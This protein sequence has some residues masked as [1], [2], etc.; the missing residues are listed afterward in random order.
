MADQNHSLFV[1]VYQGQD[2][3]ERVYMTLR[4]LEKDKLKKIDIKTAAVATRKP[5]GKIKIVHKRRVTV[6]KG[7]V[8]G[9]ALGLVVAAFTAVGGGAVLAGAVVG[10]LVGGTRSRQRRDAKEFLD[11]KLGQND[12]ALIVLVTEADWEAVHEATA[13]Y[14]GENIAVRLTP[15]AEQQIAALAE[16]EEVAAAVAEE[17]EVVEEDVQ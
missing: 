14:G 16:D 17:V 9:G 8:G 10:A 1:T 15:E 11:G 5:N 7:I 12:S 13:S 3:A 2:T 4:E 6:G